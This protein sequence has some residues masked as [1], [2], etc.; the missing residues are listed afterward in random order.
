[1]GFKTAAGKMSRDSGT[2]AV[3]PPQVPDTRGGEACSCSCAQL[4][5]DSSDYLTGSLASGINRVGIAKA[6]YWHAV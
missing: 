1:M 2:D 3:L 5:T 4:E 6:G